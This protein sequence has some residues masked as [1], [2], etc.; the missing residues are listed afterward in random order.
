[1]GKYVD[2]SFKANN[3]YYHDGTANGGKIVPLNIDE[4][5]KNLGIPYILVYELIKS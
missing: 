2:D 4:D 5:W 1:M 3:I